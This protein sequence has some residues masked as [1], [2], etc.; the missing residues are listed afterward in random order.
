[1]VGESNAGRDEVFAP[2]YTVPETPCCLLYNGYRLSFLEVQRL[3]HAFDHPPPS[4][5]EVKERVELYL[6]FL[7]GP[8]WP[9]LRRT[10]PFY[11]GKEKIWGFILI[12]LLPF[13]L[14]NNE[15]HPKNALDYIYYI[16]LKS[17]TCFGRY[18][19]SSG[20]AVIEYQEQIYSDIQ[21]KS[22]GPCKH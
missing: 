22:G 8:S 20:W 9:V 13:I 21:S 5:A 2:F 10:L 14:C 19:P 11:R 7:S 6:Y 12:C 4:S 16:K 3:Q 18:R 1:M 15:S 17:P